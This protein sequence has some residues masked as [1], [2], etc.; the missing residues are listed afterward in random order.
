M[1]K[2]PQGQTIREEL[3]TAR[4]TVLRQIEILETPFRS[5]DQ[6]P[7]GV[8]MLRAKLAEI[9]ECLAQMEPDHT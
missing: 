1:P 8:A 9:D 3:M 7:E 2:G 4:E 5:Y 6:Y